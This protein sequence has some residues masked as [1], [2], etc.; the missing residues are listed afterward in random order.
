[1]QF[2]T[3]IHNELQEASQIALE[4]FGKV[5]AIEKGE[6]NNQ[7]LNLANLAVGKHILEEIKKAFPDHNIIDKETGVSKKNSDYTWV[8]DP[9]DGTNN[10]ANGV[11]M[12]GIIIG[13]LYKDQ[14]F[15]GGISLPYFSRIVSA[16]KGEGVFS[17]G[18]PIHVT[19]EKDLLKVL[20][21]YHIDGHQDQPHITHEE[22]KKL[23]DI[24]LGIR[25]LRITE[26]SYDATLV[27]HG[28]Y[29][30][31]LNKTS[32]IWN[33]VAPQVIIEEAGG[34]YTDFYGK[35][36]D[37]TNPFEKVEENYTCCAAAPVLHQQL[38]TI[39]HKND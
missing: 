14:P 26:T 38:Q 16:E 25:N 37:Y 17:N 4:H 22:M 13:L 12:F 5:S 31:Y 23:S 15:A 6:D 7:I 32:N 9:I 29:G 2:R 8:I 3:F 34:V 11:P 36:C 39:I 30:G 18:E 20:V 10:F 21:A 27:A 33:N 24:V 19:E 1:M 28:N 35:A